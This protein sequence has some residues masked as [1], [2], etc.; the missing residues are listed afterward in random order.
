MLRVLLVGSGGFA[1]SVLRYLLSGTAQSIFRSATFPV[2]TLLVN[3]SGCFLI[4]LLSQLAESR[5]AFS[6]STRTL[7]FVGILGGYTT[8]SA[9][10]N[11]T[12]NL[13]RSGESSLAILNITAQLGGGLAC[14]W[15]GRTAAYLIWR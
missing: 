5:G 7:V 1:G 13:F 12:M 2:G 10:G 8:F 3:I 15:L 11:E 9:F 14:V 6:D 4:G